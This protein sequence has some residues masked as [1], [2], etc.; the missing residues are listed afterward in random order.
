ML[1]E[2]KNRPI[3][4]SLQSIRTMAGLL[5]GRR[6]R[7]TAGALLELSGLANERQRLQQELDRGQRRQAEIHA[8][9]EEIAAKEKR[10]Q[11]FIKTPNASSGA[12]PLPIADLPQC[13]QT[14]ELQY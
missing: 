5:D 9:L 13:V 6:A 8:R 2:R 4:K 3:K 14:R 10:L 12:R 7:S 11:K 1:N